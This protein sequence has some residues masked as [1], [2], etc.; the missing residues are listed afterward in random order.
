MVSVSRAPGCTRPLS[1]RNAGAKAISAAL[2]HPLKRAVQA[3]V[4][5][6]QR[7]FICERHFLEN[8]IELD[9]HARIASMRALNRPTSDF[10]SPLLLAYDYA[11]AFPS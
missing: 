7:G 8:L 9:S 5:P 4:A 3:A 2:N 1:L 6:S 10:A 11:H